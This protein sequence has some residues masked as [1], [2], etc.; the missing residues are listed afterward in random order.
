M[1]CN[2]AVSYVST[3]TVLTRDRWWGLQTLNTGTSA[4]SNFW[5]SKDATPHWTCLNAGTYSYRGYSAHRSIE[6]GV[7]YTS[8]T[9]NWQIPGL[10]RFAC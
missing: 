4:R 3:R 8:S 6:N 10:S 9:R 5:T 2:Y 1:K 7:S